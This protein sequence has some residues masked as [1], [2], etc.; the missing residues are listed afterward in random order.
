MNTGTSETLADYRTFTFYCCLNAMCVEDLGFSSSIFTGV[1]FN[2]GLKDKVLNDIL[3]PE[4]NVENRI[5]N[6]LKRWNGN[7]WK[8]KLCYKESLWSALWSGT[9]SYLLKPRV[10]TEL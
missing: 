10:N 8:H 5:T 1:Q 7:R 4:Y 6:M 9:W 2:P 3:F